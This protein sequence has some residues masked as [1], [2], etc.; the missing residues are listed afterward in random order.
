MGGKRT[1]QNCVVSCRR[2]QGPKLVYVA[3][4]VLEPAIYGACFSRGIFWLSLPQKRQR[5]QCN[6]YEN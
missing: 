5:A 2:L 4:D 1:K 3:G 6:V